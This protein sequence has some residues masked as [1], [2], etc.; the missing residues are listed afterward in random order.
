MCGPELTC[1]YFTEAEVPIEKD[2]A[3]TAQKV[4]FEKP[5]FH[6]GNDGQPSLENGED[7]STE[8][9]RK[10]ESAHIEKGK[11]PKEKTESDSDKDKDKKRK[12]SP[13]PHK[14]P[15][16]KPQVQF[17]LPEN[18]SVIDSEK[19]EM[20]SALGKHSVEQN[21]Q[22]VFPVKVLT[23]RFISL[24]AV[25][26]EPSHS[27]VRR[28]VP[29][30][31][32]EYTTTSN[33]IPDDLDYGEL[34]QAT[35]ELLESMYKWIFHSADGVEYVKTE[36]DRHTAI[37]PRL[38]RFYVSI[39]FRDGDGIVVP[40]Q[41]QIEDLTTESLGDGSDFYNLYLS[42]LRNLPF[43]VFV[44]TTSVSFIGDAATL[45][46][47]RHNFPEL[48]EDESNLTH[49]IAPL[50]F[51]LLALLV[52]VA[53]CSCCQ[54]RRRAR[55]DKISQKKNSTPSNNP[56][57]HDDVGMSDYRTSLFSGMST[58]LR[59]DREMD[60]NILEEELKAVMD[61]LE[62]VSLVDVEE[63]TEANSLA[64]T[65]EVSQ[66]QTENM[67]YEHDESKKPSFL[68]QQLKSFQERAV[69]IRSVGKL[70][71][72]RESRTL[73]Q[74]TDL[75]KVHY[76]EQGQSSAQTKKGSHTHFEQ[77]GIP[78]K[79]TSESKEEYVSLREPSSEQ[80]PRMYGLAPMKQASALVSKPERSD[81]EPTTES[82][83]QKSVPS[84]PRSIQE[85]KVE[86]TKTPITLRSLEPPHLAFPESSQLV[87]E[88][89]GKE[90]ATN[91]QDSTQKKRST[92]VWA[93]K[94]FLKPVKKEND[95]P[96]KKGKMPKHAG[97]VPKSASSPLKSAVYEDKGK[98]MKTPAKPLGTR[99]S[100]SSDYW[101]KKV[102]QEN[103]RDT[104]RSDAR[105]P[106]EE[107]ESLTNV[108]TGSAEKGPGTPE[109]TS[110]LLMNANGKDLA[111]TQGAKPDKG[112]ELTTRVKQL[113]NL[114]TEKQEQ[115]QTSHNE[116]K[117]RKRIEDKD[118][119]VRPH[120]DPRVAVV[121][122]VTRSTSGS[123]DGEQHSTATESSTALEDG[124]STV[125]EQTTK[126]EPPSPNRLKKSSPTSSRM[127]AK[128]SSE[129]GV[130]RCI[131][132]GVT[133]TA[134]SLQPRASG[135]PP[136]MISKESLPLVDEAILSK[137][138]EPHKKADSVAK[139]SSESTSVLSQKRPSADMSNSVVDDTETIPRRLLRASSS[140]PRTKIKENQLEV[141]GIDDVVQLKP[142]P[143]TKAP[144]ETV[145][146]LEEPSSEAEPS[147]LQKRPSPSA[148][149]EQSG[150]QSKWPK[151][152]NVTANVVDRDEK[153]P[154]PQT[155]L[156]PSEEV[157]GTTPEWLQKY[158]QM[159]IQSGN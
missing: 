88:A 154:T 113:Q 36:V 24:I 129:L 102:D 98:G 11:E 31:A 146:S 156:S 60:E 105:L 94:G 78:V 35:N 153:T 107:L 83:T 124:R 157:S 95:A 13:K 52:C 68:A 125:D 122:D 8:R 17:E 5:K 37:A 33:K 62:D 137:Q 152:Q 58:T 41:A 89:E 29:I 136:N 34:A 116:S 76:I 22:R 10:R 27:L 134:T 70:D 109:D 67:S 111:R 151:K 87:S 123:I 93:S 45:S 131:E 100:R 143:Q 61:G 21:W 85:A 26:N 1:L 140:P 57:K 81:N 96:V 6:K 133:M 112:I 114:F 86:A 144:H 14:K 118:G 120:A 9:S 101:I 97:L 72:E 18:E 99:K 108:S 28:S 79:P 80:P 71:A 12:T 132:N 54:R 39:Y 147:W 53:A 82:V 77:D 2:P 106:D 138:L 51:L 139:P 59:P 69:P 73:S 7:Q 63:D 15:A 25:S 119:E 20:E 64:D 74:T 103:R 42:R 49:V 150:E 148:V 158:A 43:G 121:S 65:A 90:P 48:D 66:S 46:R 127:E 32:F 47:D 159:G 130:S 56:Q 117:Q 128:L 141:T 149:E 110:E 38:V 75:S 55:K 16:K 91:S 126:N 4:H 30:L 155:T 40:T 3:K 104:N 84:S 19:H 135:I 23:V 44:T 145:D 50:V 142:S 92:P 115:M